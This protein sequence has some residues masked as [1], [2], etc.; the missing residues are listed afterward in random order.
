MELM[1]SVGRREPTRKSL[2]LTSQIMFL[3]ERTLFWRF[4]FSQLV[5]LGVSTLCVFPLWLNINQSARQLDIPLLFPYY[6]T[7][8][9]RYTSSN[10]KRYITIYTINALYYPLRKYCRAIMMKQKHAACLLCL[11]V[12]LS[13]FLKHICPPFSWRICLKRTNGR[14]CIGSQTFSSGS[15]IYWYL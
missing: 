7:S 11:R 2:S 9:R 3:L 14:S 10:L 15:L 8:C 1:V 5:G 4:F 6:L 12:S 13:C